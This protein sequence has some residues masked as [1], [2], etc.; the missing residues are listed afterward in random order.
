MGTVKSLRLLRSD[1][2]PKE[3]GQQEPSLS[4]RGTLPR[5]CEATGSYAN[6]GRSGLP[7]TTLGTD[8]YL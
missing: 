6:T 3:T 4:E 5:A 2:S 7:P 1:A 8:L